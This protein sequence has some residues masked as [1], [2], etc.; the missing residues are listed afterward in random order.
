[1]VEITI[2]EISKDLPAYLKRVQAGE[3]FVVLQAGTSVA[4]VVPLKPEVKSER[5]KEFLKSL[6]KFQEQMRA[7]GIN[8]DPDEIFKL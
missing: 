4:Q 2:E 1:M 6:A 5:G 7:E 8:L 3:S